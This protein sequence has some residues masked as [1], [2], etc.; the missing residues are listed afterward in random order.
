MIAGD[1]I[2]MISI[3]VTKC[4]QQPVDFTRNE[5][6]NPFTL[7]GTSY[8]LLEEC[9]AWVW[10]KYVFITYQSDHIVLRRCISRQDGWTSGYVSCY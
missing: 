1:Y 10:G 2:K 8:V 9:Y 3:G 7:E 6:S 4:Y 5:M